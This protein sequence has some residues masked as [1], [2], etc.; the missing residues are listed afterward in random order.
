M[1]AQISRPIGILAF[2]SVLLA[3]G[4]FAAPNRAT[5]ADC[6]TAPGSATPPNGHWYYRTNR[7]QQRKCWFL[8]TD[9]PDSQ[10]V[11]APATGEAPLDQPVQSA[12]SITNSLA[13]FKE[14][15]TQ[16]TGVAPSNQEVEKLYAEFLK[17]NG[18]AK[19]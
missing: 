13:S 16:R 8:R 12:S 14:F 7:T 5:A 3:L 17:W 4:A 6:L 2:A 11:S 9:N 15:M 18:R 19:D 1:S 10:R